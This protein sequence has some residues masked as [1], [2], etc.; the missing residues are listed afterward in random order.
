MLNG[1]HEAMRLGMNF[2]ISVTSSWEHSAAVFIAQEGQKSSEV[3][4]LLF[5]LN[6]VDDHVS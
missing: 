4:V 6:A 1:L 2:K 3:S 5:L